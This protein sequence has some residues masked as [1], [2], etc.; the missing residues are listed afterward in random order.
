MMSRDELRTKLAVLLEE[1]MGEAYDNLEDERDLRDGLG[2]DSVDVVGL[3]MRIEREYHI[4]L[5][6]EELQEIKVVG[7]MLDLLEAK[8]ANQPVAEDGESRAA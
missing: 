7:E 4:R 3:V 1:E 6:M 8:L 5:T 2:L